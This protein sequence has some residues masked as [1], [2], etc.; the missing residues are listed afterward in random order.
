MS[1]QPGR[2]VARIV[3]QVDGEPRVD[4]AVAGFAPGADE[5][6]EIAVAPA[7]READFETLVREPTHSLNPNVMRIRAVQAL[8]TCGRP[9]SVEVIAP[10]AKS[11]AYFNGLT[12]IA[13]ATLVTLAEKHRKSR[14]A[15]QNVLRQ[16]YPIPPDPSDTRAMRACIALAKRVHK[17]L[18]ARKKFPDPYDEAA[19]K[20]LMEK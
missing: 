10:H 13:I 20:K 7:G 11:G 1:I 4:L 19:R 2:V 5:L 14:D 15:V 16:A 3:E 18:G 8:A 17:A 6:I 9:E 12:G